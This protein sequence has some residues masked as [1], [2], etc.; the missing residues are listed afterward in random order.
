MKVKRYFAADVRQGLRQIRHEMG[1]DAVILSSNQVDGG[2][3]IVAAIDYDET[4]FRTPND[5]TAASADNMSVAEVRSRQSATASKSKD[6]HYTL[7]DGGGRRQSSTTAADEQITWSQDPVLVEMRTEIKNLRNMVE[8]QLSGFAWGDLTR[9][10]P[11]RAELLQR[12]LKLGLSIAC[13][14]RLLHDISEQ[15]DIEANWRHLL[16]QLVSRIQCGD[17]EIIRRGG[18]VALVGPTGVGKTTTL[19]KLAA[20]YAFKEGVRNVALVT[21]DNY[22]IGAHDQIRTYGRILGVPVRIVNDRKELAGTLAELTNKSLVLID[23][24][25][26][27]QRDLRLVEQFSRLRDTPREIRS[28]L[29]VSATTMHS[30][31]NEIVS[32]FAHVSPCGCILTKVDEATNLGAV[33]STLVDYQLPLSYTCDG[34]RV[35]EDIHLAR[36]HSLVSRAV[37][38]M[39]NADRAIDEECMAL[40][41]GRKIANA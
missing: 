3:E 4:V 17:D 14:Q 8:N 38:L 27:G 33:L 10:H 5:K 19:A 22:R 9:R 7:A 12:L 41:N 32:S 28:Y 2:V 20:R 31:L 34:Q 21:T 23:T 11:L 1:S 30:A 29:V 6:M 26:M 18:V 25:G 24:A 15:R 13:C 39:E 37:A 35:P 40:T 36:P 16:D